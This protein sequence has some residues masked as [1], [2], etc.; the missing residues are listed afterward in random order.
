MCTPIKNDRIVKRAVRRRLEIPHPENGIPL[1]TVFQFFLEISF[2]FRLA[3]AAETASMA[4]CTSDVGYAISSN[5]SGLLRC[6][7][8]VFWRLHSS[9]AVARM[10]LARNSGR[11][12]SCCMICFAFSPGTNRTISDPNLTKPDQRRKH[13]RRKCQF[14]GSSGGI[15]GDRVFR[16]TCRSTSVF[17]KTRSIS[18]KGNAVKNFLTWKKTKRGSQPNS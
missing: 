2:V 7:Q 4:R 18:P 14:C 8:P 5:S 12:L 6:T 11:S 17:P 9:I 15:A 16:G 13:P 3:D 1:E 10:C